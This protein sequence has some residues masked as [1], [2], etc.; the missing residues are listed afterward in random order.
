MI[1]LSLIVYSVIVYFQMSQCISETEDLRKKISTLINASP[2]P[3]EGNKPLIDQDI[4]LYT[5][6]NK[7][8]SSPIGRPYQ[9][10]ADRFVEV[11]MGVKKGESVEEA[12]KKFVEEYNNSVGKFDNRQAEQAIELRKLERKY[13]RTLDP[14]LRAFKKIVE[15][16]TLEPD[17]DSDTIEFAFFTI[18]IP[19]K[20]Q[21]EREPGKQFMVYCRKYQDKIRQMLGPKMR[22]EADA[23]GF[24]FLGD[25]SASTSVST[26][27]PEGGENQTAVAGP[28]RR[29][30]IPRIARLWDIVGDICRRIN[31]VDGLKSLNFFRIRGIAN[32]AYEN[33]FSSQGNYITSHYSFEVIAPL[34]DIRALAEAFAYDPAVGRFYIVRS[35]FIYAPE[36]E[37]AAARQLLTPAVTTEAESDKKDQ[38]TP[39][40]R[41]GRRGAVVEE[42]PQNN[43]EKDKQKELQ[44]KW[45]E[46]FEKREKSLPFY[47]RSGY[48]DVKLGGV[49]DFRAVF[50]VEY[51]ERT[52]LY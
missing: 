42:E 30:D 27:S 32:G 9:K 22:P 45:R 40:R 5:N 35:V 12:R 39:V 49:T 23:L 15:P 11:L 36:T 1:I 19:R 51:V 10:A 28:F 14:A 38:P 43:A 17:L 20:M 2:A 4:Q 25:A 47:Q 31:S 33:V 13:A 7:T 16:L 34:K 50:D 3:V 21:G 52:G 41:R 29:D 48:G 18:G 37:I 46:E 8:I 26:P 44:A 24:S 6:L